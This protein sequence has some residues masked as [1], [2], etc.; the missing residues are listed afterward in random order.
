MYLVRRAAASAVFTFFVFALAVGQGECSPRSLPTPCH[1]DTANPWP[2][3]PPA[4]GGRMTSALM[5]RNCRRAFPNSRSSSVPRLS[6]DQS[7]ART[8]FRRP[9]PDD[10]PGHEPVRHL[11]R[12]R[13]TDRPG[14]AARDADGGGAH[15]PEH[16][17][18]GAGAAG[19]GRR[20]P[21]AAEAGRGGVSAETRRDVKVPGQGPAA[22]PLPTC[23]AVTAAAATAAPSRPDCPTRP[24][25]R[26][27]KRPR[28]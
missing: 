10:P 7:A 22:R 9:R 8:C 28:L 19:A 12:L 15:R 6:K 4:R 11:R 16:R 26:P 20:L 5:R 25:G 27:R 13:V 2:A 3:R 23:P 17:P 1:G 24:T 14:H 21:A 18:G